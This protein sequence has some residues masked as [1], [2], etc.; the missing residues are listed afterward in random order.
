LLFCLDKRYLV[1]FIYHPPNIKM[2]LWCSYE[3]ER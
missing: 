3:R 1:W 2:I